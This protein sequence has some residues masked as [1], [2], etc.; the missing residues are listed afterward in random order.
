MVDKSY[1]PYSATLITKNNRTMQIRPEPV[2]CA[3]I[4]DAG[5]GQM[6]QGAGLD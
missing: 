3:G 6:R 2:Y 4:Q 1:P 5:A